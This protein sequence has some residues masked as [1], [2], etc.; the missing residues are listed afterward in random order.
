MSLRSGFL[1]EYR[2][3]GP[4]QG[5]LERVL[6][7]GRAFLTVSGLI[8]IYLDPTEPTRLRAVTYSVLL[9]YALYSVAVLIYVHRSTAVTRLHGRALHGLDIAWT[10]ALTLISEGPVSPFF[11]FFL[12]VLLAAAY[13]G[14]FRATISTAL[15]SV[16]VFLVETA[17]VVGSPWKATWFAEFDFE[18]NSTILRVAYLLMT[19]VVLGY[20]AEQEKQS[21]AELAAI[22]DATRQPRVTLGLGGSIAA[23]GR[24]LLSAFGAG[25][26]AVV[27]ADHENR[28]TLLWRLNR[29]GRENETPSVRREE[30]DPQGRA[31]W[32]FKDFGTAWH[33]GPGGGITPITAVVSGDMSLNRHDGEL[34]ADFRAA[35]RFQIVT[36][37]N[38]ELAG[39]WQARIYLFD[40]SRADSP[41]RTLHFLA[42]L[43]EHVTPALTNVFLLRRLR[44]RAGAAERARVARELHD[45]TIQALFAIEMKL[46]AFRRAPDRS[47]A[48]I[49]TEVAAIQELLRREVLSLRELMQALRP[50]E[51]E[52]ADQLPDALAALVERFRRDT[53]I[54]ARFVASGAGVPVSPKT[55][56]EIVRIVQEA[57]A[58]VRRHAGARNVLVSLSTVDGQSRLVVEDDGCGFAFEGR[59]SARELDHLHIGP[60]VIKERARIAGAELT[61]ESVR[62]AGARVELTFAEEFVHA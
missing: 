18:L 28:R 29:P 33:A 15:V 26:V 19:G 16:A 39:E 41:E 56:L 17:L 37:V 54:F 23:V 36:A 50:I 55:A 13:R 25:A 11:L 46:E 3:V 1:G 45:G 62:G 12:F 8:A 60:A 31:T 43:A 58:N 40:P 53:G 24:M 21:R 9:G 20:M 5:Q 30:L 14:G 35:H 38:M 42:A 51:L 34:P 44:V 22:A 49:D 61:V 47:P 52:G 10:S 57:L 6:A 27:L 2:S 59:L 7:V 32:L 4:P 48:F